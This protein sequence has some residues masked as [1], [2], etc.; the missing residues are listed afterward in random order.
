MV[1]SVYLLCADNCSSRGQQEGPA[2]SK[3]GAAGVSGT[4]GAFRARR[5]DSLVELA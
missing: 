1:I 5:F 2:I 3:G 4:D